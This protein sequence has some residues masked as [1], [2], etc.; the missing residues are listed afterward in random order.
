MSKNETKDENL[1]V[2]EGVSGTWFYHLSDGRTNALS[3]CG[4]KTMYTAI[5]L[6]SWGVKGSLNERYCSEC[7]RMGEDELRAAGVVVP[8]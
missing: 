6:S 8:A 4:T 1:H 3:L 5:P 2:T 7:Q